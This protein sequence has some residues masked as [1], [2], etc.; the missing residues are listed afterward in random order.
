MAGRYDVVVI[1]A[2]LG[3]LT[4]AA[5]L[6]RAGRQ[7]LVLERN[8]S[9]GGAASTYRVGDLAVEASLHETADPHDPREPKHSVLARIGILDAVQW[10]PVG[11]LYEV[12]GG[13]V[14]A[15]FCLPDGFA[16][17]RAALAERFPAARDGFEA[18]LGDMEKIAIGLGTLNRGRDAFR[19]PREGF[20]ALLKLKPVLRDWQRSLADVFARALG[21]NEAAKFA[22]AANLPY[23]SD[24][25]AKLWWVMFAVA[26]GGYLAS[27][28]RYVRG[29]S[30]RLSDA[31]AGAVT[32]ASGEIL[33]ERNAIEIRLGAGGRPT[34]VVHTDRMGGDRAEAATRAVAGNAAPAVLAD[35][36]SGPARERFDTAYGGRP[37]SPSLFSAMLGLS[38]PPSTFG[39]RSYSN[40]LLPAWIERL[41]DFPRCAE[42]LGAA[43][44]KG[45]DPVITVV[46]YSAIDSGL[47]GPPYPVSV[48]GLDRVDN[49]AG[50]D[51]AGEET[52][53]RQWTERIVAIIDAEFPGFAAQ[54]VASTFSSA[55]AIARYLNA[56][57]GAVYGFATL[58][59]RRP[60]W[61]GIDR[62][63]KTPVAGLYLASAYAGSGGFT[64]AIRSGAAAADTIIADM[65]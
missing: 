22:L 40:F 24:D 6:A 47:G 26:Q 31:L 61:H 33:L 58:P 41:A 29:G 56:P 1:G 14:G 2:G 16:G 48:V 15:A 8:R 13:P 57:R 44:V 34:A 11:S 55:R 53:R 30:Q 59:P 39:L 46:D 43:P 21:D 28:G 32:A 60:I 19:N 42:L 65:T 12:R 5:L 17:A 54:V 23:W 27:G 63:P 37:L 50:L 20:A 9:V 52:R 38:K 10:V 4:A 18:V 25:P 45:M 35:M 7:V 3:G 36:L 62:S 51:R 49:W 64:G